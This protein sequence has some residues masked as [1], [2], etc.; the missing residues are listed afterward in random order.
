MQEELAWAMRHREYHQTNDLKRMVISLEDLNAFS[1]ACRDHLMTLR[2]TIIVGE[3][4]SENARFRFKTSQYPPFRREKYDTVSSW[5][6]S[7]KLMTAHA[8]Y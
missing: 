6:E 4:S 7:S 1:I 2:Q 5:L 8:Q 3:K